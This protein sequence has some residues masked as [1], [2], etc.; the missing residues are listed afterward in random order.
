MAT[1]GKNAAFLFGATSATATTYNADDCLQGWDLA[2]SI[3]D[4][5]YQCNGYDK[6]AA[7]TKVISFRTA[8]A[9]NSSDVA[10][11]CGFV[12]GTTGWF[13]GAPGGWTTGA[14]LAIKATKATIISAPISAPVNGI[15]SIDLELA[16]DDVEYTSC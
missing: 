9:L 14:Y 2:S 7:G 11:T 1:G 6:H 16:L 12:P 13:A 3:N 8:L 10:L 15:C 4:I 5:V